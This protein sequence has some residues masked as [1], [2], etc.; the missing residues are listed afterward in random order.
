MGGFVLRK[1]TP[2]MRMIGQDSLKTR[3]TLSVD[4]KTYHYFSLPEAAK[5]IGDISKAAPWAVYGVVLI[6]VMF[7]MPG[8]VVGLLRSTAARW[9]RSA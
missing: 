8:G 6:A 3:R 7:A 2:T 5:S 9:R 4:G 1:G